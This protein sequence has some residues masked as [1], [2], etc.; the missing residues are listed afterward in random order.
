[1][2]SPLPSGDYSNTYELS[3]GNRYFYGHSNQNEG[4]LLH[5]NLQRFRHTYGDGNADCDSHVHGDDNADR[6]SNLDLGV[7]A[8]SLRYAVAHR[9]GYGDANRDPNA[10]G[11][12]DPR[13]YFDADLYADA[14]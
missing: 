12:G 11:Y 6:D 4:S 10:H 1:V 5:S 9:H 13:R 2:E 8:Y 7:D 14:D 3:H